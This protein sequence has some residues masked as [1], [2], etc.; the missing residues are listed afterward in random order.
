MTLETVAI[1]CKHTLGSRVMPRPRL[2]ALVTDF[3]AVA[4]CERPADTMLAYAL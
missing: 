3:A 2:G 4:R 1:F